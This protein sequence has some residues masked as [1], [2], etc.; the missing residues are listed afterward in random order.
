M[1]YKFVRRDLKAAM[2]SA[3]NLAAILSLAS[4]SSI[5]TLVQKF[6]QVF[7]IFQSINTWFH[8]ALIIIVFIGRPD[9]ILSQSEYELIRVILS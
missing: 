2:R 1:R 4:F 6:D 3:L 5:L 7:T 8:H 9:S